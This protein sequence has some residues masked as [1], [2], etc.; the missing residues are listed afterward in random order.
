M[1]HNQTKVNSRTLSM[2]T[3]VCYRSEIHRR[4]GT[5]GLT[6]STAAIFLSR[7]A[8]NFRRQLMFILLMITG[9]TSLAAQSPETEFREAT[10][11]VDGHALHYRIAGNGPVLLMLHGFTLTGEQW[12]PFAEA[13]TDSHTVVVADLPGHGSSSPLPGT[14]SFNKAARLMHGLLDKLDADSYR[15]IGHSG[16]GMALLYMAAQQ[17]DRVTSMVLVNTPHYF[18]PAAREIAREDTWE[19]LD[20]EVQKWYINL[21][22]GGLEQAQRIYRQFNGLA[23]STEKVTP[24]IL[25]TVPATTLLVWGDRDPALPVEMPLEM[26]RALP[27]AALW[28]I[29][30]QGHTPI[31]KEL[32][33]NAGAAEQ[34]VAIAKSFL[35]KE[36]VN[37]VAWF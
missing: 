2:E 32:G 8:S 4:I 12:M 10:A 6:A 5:S 13:F 1:K 35:N 3:L 9:L 24:E 14:F 15:G 22:P 36:R 21:H 25:K 37:S 19:R 31:F 7:I 28:V 18:G 34:F 11:K 26:Y 20:P 33:G 23:K 29:P 27:N 16:G 17:P 30:E